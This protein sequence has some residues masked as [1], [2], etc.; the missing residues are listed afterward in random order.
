MQNTCSN[1]PHKEIGE[2]CP[3]S[4]LSDRVKQMACVF[5]Q[6]P[7]F[8]AV[9]PPKVVKQPEASPVQGYIRVSYWDFQ[10]LILN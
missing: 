5:L 10:P 7:A 8:V 9:F 6:T 3:F 4:N 2:G 1:C